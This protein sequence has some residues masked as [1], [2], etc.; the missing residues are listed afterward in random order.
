[1]LAITVDTAL[2]VVDANDGVTSLRE[3]IFAANTLSGADTI[4]F[5]PELTAEG[6]TTILITQGELAIIDALTI[7]GP[8]AELLTI[9]AQQ[10]SRVFNITATSGDFSL[11]ELSVTGGRTTAD[12]PMGSNLWCGGAIRSLTDGMLTLD[13]MIFAGNGTTGFHSSGGAIFT[14]AGL[15]LSD[16]IV[17]RN[18]TTG[19]T[20]YGGGISAGGDAMIQGSAVRDNWTVAAEIGAIN[21]V[22][23]VTLVNSIVTRNVAMNLSVGVAIIAAQ[24]LRIVGSNVTDNSGAGAHASKIARFCRARFPGIHWQEFDLKE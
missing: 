5:A 18:Y 3:A 12:T 1:M 10:Q 15:M 11:S 22:R 2:D 7:N 14:H 17:E 24:D 9:D 16:S 23:S 4:E 19:S 6:P 20:A 21:G 13:R 8:G